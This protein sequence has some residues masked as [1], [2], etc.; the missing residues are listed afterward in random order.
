[1]AYNDATLG[2]D[3]RGRLCFS[4]CIDIQSVLPTIDIGEIKEEVGRLVRQLSTPKG[5]FIGTFY[6]KPDLA[7]PLEK[8]AEMVEAMKKFSFLY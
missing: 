2:A 3:V 7:I 8:N 4:T 6:G 5:G 1:M